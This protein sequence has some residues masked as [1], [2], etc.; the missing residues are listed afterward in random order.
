MTNVRLKRLTNA[1]LVLLTDSEKHFPGRIDKSKETEYYF[2]ETMPAFC[3]KRP[4][5]AM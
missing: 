4:L 1:Y 3:F 2:R 5:K